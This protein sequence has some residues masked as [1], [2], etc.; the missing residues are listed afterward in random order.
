[1][2]INR[3]VELVSKH[4]GVPQ[5]DVLKVLDA[6]QR[7]GGVI[8]YNEHQLGRALPGPFDDPDVRCRS[9]SMIVG[10]PG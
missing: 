5:S 3:Y 10:N 6:V 2:L 1:M 8:I 9:G 4:T 7:F